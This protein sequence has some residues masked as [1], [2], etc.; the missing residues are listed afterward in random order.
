[1]RPN[2]TADIHEV[3]PTS[4]VDVY[5]YGICIDNVTP[6]ALKFIDMSGNKLEKKI[7]K[8]RQDCYTIHSDIDVVLMCFSM[9]DPISFANVSKKVSS[10]ISYKLI[11]DL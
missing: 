9:V 11:S 10:F 2:L 6:A 8:M 7:A 4:M 1:M 3:T 5:H